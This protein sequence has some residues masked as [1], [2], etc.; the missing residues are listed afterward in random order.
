MAEFLLF[1]DDT[2]IFRSDHDIVELFSTMNN[3]LNN[4][5]LWP[6]AKFF[7]LKINKNSYTFFI[8]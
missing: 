6:V 4:I 7:S 8:Q 2:N 1:A 3:E 5:L